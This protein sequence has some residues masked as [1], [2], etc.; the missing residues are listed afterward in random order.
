MIYA[1]LCA[2]GGENDSLYLVRLGWVRLGW[3]RLRYVR[4]G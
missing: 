4:L 3:V 2:F 1:L